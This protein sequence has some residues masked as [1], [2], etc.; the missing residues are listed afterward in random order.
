MDRLALERPT[1]TSATKHRVHSGKLLNLRSCY[2]IL[3]SLTRL[4][5]SRENDLYPT[6]RDAD[7]PR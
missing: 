4:R 6:I 5:M 3:P 2:M 7:P 1:R